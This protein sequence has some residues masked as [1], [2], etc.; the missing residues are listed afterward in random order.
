MHRQVR[1]VTDMSINEGYAD[2]MTSFADL[3][4][5]EKAVRLADEN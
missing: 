2:F 1:E 5:Q 4:T 3:S